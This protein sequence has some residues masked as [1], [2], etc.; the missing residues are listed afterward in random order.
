VE[1]RWVRRSTNGLADII[2]N[3]GVD[4][5]GPELGSTWIKIPNGQFRTDCTQLAANDYDGSQSTD[6]HIEDEGTQL[7]EGK[8]EFRKNMIGHHLNTSYNADHGHTTRG[9]TTPKSYQ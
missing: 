4:K 6:D 2:A 5:E 1:L 7:I 9:G 8:R 3:E